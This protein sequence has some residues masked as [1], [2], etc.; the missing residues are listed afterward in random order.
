VSEQERDLVYAL[1]GKQRPQ[2]DGVSD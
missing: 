2:G 1:A